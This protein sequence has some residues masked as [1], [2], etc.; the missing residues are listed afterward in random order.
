MEYHVAETFYTDPHHNIVGFHIDE[1]VYAPLYYGYGGPGEYADRRWYARH[2]EGTIANRA[3][4]TVLVLVK[5]SPDVIARRMKENPHKNGVLQEKDIEHVLQRFEEE[6]G[7]SFIR[8]KFSLDTSTATV[9]ESLAEFVESL[10]PHL[11]DADR[12]KIMSRQL[13]RLSTI[14][15]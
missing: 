5:A 7:S 8:V 14:Q 2:I 11:P 9:E 10:E 1:A 4:D 3:P 12:L 15:E 6:F 13:S